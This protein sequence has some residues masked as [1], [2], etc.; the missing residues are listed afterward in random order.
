MKLTKSEQQI[1]QLLQHNKSTLEIAA[2]LQ[3]SESTVKNH[4]GHIYKKTGEV[5]RTGVAV[6]AT[7]EQYH[8]YGADLMKYAQHRGNCAFVTYGRNCNCGLEEVVRKV[9]SVW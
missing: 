2:I 4:L 7:K 1:V 3:I 9:K 6:R 8:N 5:S